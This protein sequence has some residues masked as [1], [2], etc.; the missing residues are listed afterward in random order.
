MTLTSLHRAATGLALTG[1]AVL[2]SVAGAP[3]A[4][5][6]PDRTT[7][8]AGAAAGHTERGRLVAARPLRVLST[9]GAVAQTLRAAEFDPGP[10]RHG[11]DTYQ[12]V[13]HTIDPAGRPTTA[14]GLL[15]LPRTR[16]R[17]LRT[18]S[19][20]HGTELHRGDAPSVSSDGWAVAPALTYASAGFAAV[21]P[22]YLGLGHG[23]GPHPYL[24]VP[25]E[26]TAAVDLLRAAREFVP[27]T[28]RQLRREVLVTGFSQG[29]TAATGLA[30]ALQGGAD[31][32]FR[33][34]ALAPIS[35]AYDFGG[36]ELPA[37]LD[38]SIGYPYDVVY[39]AYLTVSWNRLHHLYDRPG[40]VFTADYADTVEGLFDGGH[41]GAQVVAALPSSVGEL[42]TERGLQLLRHPEGAFAAA[43]RVHDATCSDWVPRVPV[44]LYVTSRD[45][46]ALPANT[47]HCLAALRTGGAQV[48][49][50][51][52]GEVAYGGSAHLG[53]NVRATA[54]IAEWFRRR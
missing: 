34:A 9:A 51:D 53:S 23:P 45:V 26:T 54:L 10:V 38:G 16:E 48:S 29:A 28:G 36:V 37:L 40:D 13:Y 8:A 3:P 7:T 31:E 5:A 25:S 4:V 2:T 49:L 43:L 41:T 30:R 27:R 12:L 44:R 42:F 19:Y 24:D 22:D 18:V 39:L 46:E 50:V 15:A 35:G 11:V 33:L 14:T 17:A 52:L 1:L 32:W 20:T 47:T 6:G 21:A